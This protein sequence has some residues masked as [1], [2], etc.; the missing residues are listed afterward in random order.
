MR[1]V[2]LAL[3]LVWIAVPAL[4]QGLGGL[5]GT[6][7]DSVRRRRSK[8]EDY[9]H[10]SRNWFFSEHHYQSR[11]LFHDSLCPACSL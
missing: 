11:R 3:S 7:T 5:I 1:L 4:S 10:R 6:V 9:G 2:A 8:R